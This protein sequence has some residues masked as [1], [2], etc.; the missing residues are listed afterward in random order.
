MTDYLFACE[1]IDNSSEMLISI[2]EKQ[3]PDLIRQQIVKLNELDVSVKAALNAAQEA[4]KCASAA[5]E[6]SAG[7][8]FL[9][10]KKREAIEGL[11]SAGI[12]LAQAV[13][14]GANS[15]KISFEFQIRLTEV[16]RYLFNL[17]AH[18]IAAR[19]YVVREL[20]M[21]LSGASREELSDLAHQE[22]LTVVRQLKEQEDLLRKQTRMVSV[23][24]D[25]D[26]KIERLLERGDTLALNVEQTQARQLAHA[27]GIQAI[28]EIVARQRLAISALKQQASAHRDQT[29]QLQAALNAANVNS[30]LVE[31]SLRRALN[32]RTTILVVMFALLAG[33]VLL[34][35][36]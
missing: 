13:Q 32:L 34:H 30:E 18:S 6:L 10:D 17:G 24:T 5:K 21:R 1:E 14:I 8:A 19:R 27:N 16:T 12:Q 22:V 26:E 29:E 11:Q 28:E 23:L 31:A 4:E 9:Q 2:D 20:E 15:Q 36:A 7:R 25:H 33:V 3:L 35:Q